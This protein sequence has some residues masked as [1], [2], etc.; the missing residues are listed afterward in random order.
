ML[1]G[2]LSLTHTILL[3]NALVSKQITFNAHL[4]ITPDGYTRYPDDLRFVS[5]DEHLLVHSG[6]TLKSRPTIVYRPRSLQA[7]HDARRQS[8]QYRE[9]PAEPLEWDVNEVLGPDV[10]D[11]HTLAQLARMSGNA[12]AL[13]G[14]PNWYEVDRA[15]NQVIILCVSIYRHVISLFLTRV[16][17]LAGKMRPMVSEDMY[18]SL[19][20]IQPSF[21]PLRAR[22]STG[23]LRGRID[24][25]TICMHIY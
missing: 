7:L 15:W 13:P 2:L 12:Y 25:T 3:V 10:E 17:P 9:S 24:S 21:F 5:S 19:K 4:G 14:F 11:R 16:S 23:R 22:L 18:S 1:L 6:V 8:L 20:I